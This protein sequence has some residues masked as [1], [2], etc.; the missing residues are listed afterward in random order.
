MRV[1]DMLKRSSKFAY[2]AQSD[3]IPPSEFLYCGERR[4][5]GWA[6]PRVYVEHPDRAPWDIAPFL[7]P[8][9]L[10]ATPATFRQFADLLTTDV[11][12]VFDVPMADKTFKLLNVVLVLDCLDVG[13][14]AFVEY[15]DGSRGPPERYVFDGSRI[16]SSIFKLK[17]TPCGAPLVVEQ[18]GSDTFKSRFDRLGYKGIEFRLLWSDEGS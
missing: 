10:V 11:V 18:A 6:P 5:A 12:E 14:T 3:D 16:T 17:Q 1:Y 2:L 7:G 9:A 15:D 8:S 13:R 4:G